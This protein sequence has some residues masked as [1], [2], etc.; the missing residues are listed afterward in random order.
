MKTKRDFISEITINEANFKYC[1]E[2]GVINGILL[3]G[4]E[5]AIQGYTDQQL[6]LHG[7]GNQRALLIAFTERCNRFRT[8]QEE[9]LIDEIDIFMDSNL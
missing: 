7:V 6:R 3:A 2:N 4:I 8:T 1:A 5:N 9:I